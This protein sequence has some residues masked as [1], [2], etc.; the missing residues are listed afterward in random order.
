MLKQKYQ[1][2]IAVAIDGGGAFLKKANTPCF[3]KIFEKGAVTYQA[4]SSN[5]TISAECYGS[6]LTGTAPQIHGLTNSIL[7][8]TPYSTTSQFPSLFRRI[9]EVMPEAVL[10]SYCDWNPITYGIVEN[11]LNVSHDTA[12]DTELTPIIC[13]YIKEKKPTFLFVQLDSVDGAGHKFGYGTP[14]HLNRIT[15]VDLLVNDIYSAVSE[16]GILDDSL[17]MVITDHGGYGNS[18]GGWTDSEKYVTFGVVGK[19]VKNNT[20][21][22]M[23]IRDLS[24]IVLYALGIQIPD[25]DEKG[26]TSQIPMGI[27]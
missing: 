14:Q 16:A 17:F 23:N 7:C 2:V 13:S 4:L 21:Q 11:N 3:D 10:G 15:E 9:R 5:P 25:F 12:R 26:W 18:H 8:S 20:I 19:N 6:M 1:H 22:E 27:W 24:A